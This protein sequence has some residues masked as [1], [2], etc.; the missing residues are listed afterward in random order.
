MLVILLIEVNLLV[1]P[2]RGSERSMSSLGIVSLFFFPLLVTLCSSRM[3][4]RLLSCILS[5]V[6]CSGCTVDYLSA[7]LVQ[8]CCINL[9]FGTVIIR[10]CQGHEQE[11]VV[12]YSCGR[13]QGSVY[14]SAVGCILDTCLRMVFVL[15]KSSH[16]PQILILFW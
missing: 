14:M 16:M 2:A 4:D 1:T 13:V 5:E 15:G 11:V 3:C 8:V 9:P 10:I 7:P 6:L 12:R